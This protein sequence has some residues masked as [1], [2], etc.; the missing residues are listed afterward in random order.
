MLLSAI[1]WPY[2]LIDGVTLINVIPGCHGRNVISGCQGR[3]QQ[4][5]AGVGIGLKGD[6][7]I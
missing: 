4:A 2:R 1:C 3:K 6:L 5:D 7:K